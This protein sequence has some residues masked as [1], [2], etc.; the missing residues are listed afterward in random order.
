ML[1]LLIFAV[2]LIFFDVEHPGAILARRVFSSVLV[3]LVKVHGTGYGAERQART[4]KQPPGL[5]FFFSQVMAVNI[6]V[7]HNYLWQC[8]T[9]RRPCCFL[10]LTR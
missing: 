4:L 10:P 2:R 8:G 7:A 3:V 6:R 5:P 9:L 1:R